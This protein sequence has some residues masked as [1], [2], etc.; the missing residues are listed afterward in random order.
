[1]WETKG[2]TEP[3]TWAE[4][5]VSVYMEKPS[6]TAKSP[7]GWI[8]M[9]DQ[10]PDVYFRPQDLDAALCELLRKGRIQHT[11]VNARVY[12]RTNGRDR[13]TREVQFLEE[14]GDVQG[15]VQR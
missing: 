2:W 4:G 9:R 6:P 3:G 8:R 14:E 5:R 10:G 11:R 1:M 15:D 13:W 12:Y 7:A